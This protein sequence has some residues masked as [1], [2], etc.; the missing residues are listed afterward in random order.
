MDFTYDGNLEFEEVFIKVPIHRNKIKVEYS[1]E[2]D[3]N[4]SS[5]I[6]FHHQPKNPNKSLIA[7]RLTQ[8]S[9]TLSSAT[10]DDNNNCI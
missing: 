8:F 6:T 3:S 1:K 7:T 10:I 2:K 5:S 9:I 4:K